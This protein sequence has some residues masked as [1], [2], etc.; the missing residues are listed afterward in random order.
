MSHVK[1]KTNIHSSWICVDKKKLD[2]RFLCM[3]ISLKINWN[4][5]QVV[6]IENDK[7]WWHIQQ[8]QHH[9]S[10]QG[11]VKQ[12]KMN[13]KDVTKTTICIKHITMTLM[14]TC[15]SV[16]RF[17]WCFRRSKNLNSVSVLSLFLLRGVKYSLEPS[18]CLFLI[19]PPICRLKTHCHFCNQY[20]WRAQSVYSATMRDFVLSISFHFDGSQIILIRPYLVL[21]MYHSLVSLL[22]LSLYLQ[23]ENIYS[24]PLRAQTFGNKILV[25]KKNFSVRFIRNLRWMNNWKLSRFDETIEQIKSTCHMCYRL[26]IEAM[27]AQLWLSRLLFH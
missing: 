9:H 10:T 13:T 15:F 17:W 8:L 21:T 18:K 16:C 5:I 25:A 20:F 23:W 1:R 7:Q 14:C 27:S 24:A 26:P 3:W 22:Y 19:V 11:D 6:P 4:F 2:W 12:K